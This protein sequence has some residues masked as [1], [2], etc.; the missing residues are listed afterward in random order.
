M[1]VDR[2]TGWYV[3]CGMWGEDM[4][5]STRLDSLLTVLQPT[6]LGHVSHSRTARRRRQSHT[7]PHPVRIPS[8][9]IH[10]V[11]DHSVLLSLVRCEHWHS[12]AVMGR[13]SPPQTH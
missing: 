4:T 13:W 11:S 1:C 9:L 12:T 2:K 3:V 10:H 7:R 5:G 6:K 8:P